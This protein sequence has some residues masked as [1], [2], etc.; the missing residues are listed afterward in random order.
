M[1][2]YLKGDS[3]LKHFLLTL[4]AAALLLC[5]VGSA[6]ATGNLV[7][8]GGF[9]TGNFD[10]WTLTGNTGYLGVASYA[11]HSGN[12]GA[13]FGAIGSPTYLTQSQNLSTTAGDTYTLSFWLKN[14]GGPYKRVLG[15]VGWEYGR[16]AE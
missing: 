1:F 2:Y 3:V 16:T 8:N 11:A 10:G 12:Y 14:N 4:S 7:V 13:F 6:R 9:E 5:A 15:L